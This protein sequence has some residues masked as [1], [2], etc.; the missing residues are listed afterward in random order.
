MEQYVVGEVQ[1]YDA[2]IDSKGQPIF[3]TGNVSPVPIM[4]IVN[5]N[6]NS[7]FY[8]VKDLPED[9]RKL[10]RATVAS[11]GVKSRFIHF[12]FFRL[13]QDMDGL[14]KKASS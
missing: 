3:E 4:D 6:D 10:G 7:V 11:F 8:I 5:N 1:S 2:I 13:L 9:M 12:E 14:A